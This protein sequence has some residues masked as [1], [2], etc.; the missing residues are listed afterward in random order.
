MLESGLDTDE[1]G[2]QGGG[3][4]PRRVEINPGKVS[5]CAAVR[6]TL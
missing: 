1:R 6:W 2:S 4:V 5:Y 3:V